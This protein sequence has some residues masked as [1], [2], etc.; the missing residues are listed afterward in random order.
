MIRRAPQRD[1]MSKRRPLYQEREDNLNRDADNGDNEYDPKEG[2]E[3][4][5]EEEE[6]G[7]VTIQQV[8]SSLTL[9]K[10]RMRTRVTSAIPQSSKPLRAPQSPL[11]IP[12]PAFKQPHAPQV[13]LVHSGPC[14]AGRGALVRLLKCIIREFCDV[15]YS[16]ACPPVVQRI[17]IAKKKKIA[18][19]SSGTKPT[20][21]TSWRRQSDWRAQP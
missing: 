4:E 18:G 13:Q 11:A 16:A 6:D 20:K 2:E 12:A 9:L 7:D 19:P 10:R 1:R 15:A 14:F 5:E 21:N 8:Q 17:K 3:E